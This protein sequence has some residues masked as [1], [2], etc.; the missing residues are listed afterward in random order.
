ML[1]GLHLFALVLSLT[2]LFC[3]ILQI[4]RLRVLSLYFNRDTILQFFSWIIYGQN[5][6]AQPLKI[7]DIY[8]SIGL[9]S[10]NKIQKDRLDILKLLGKKIM[11]T[12]N[13]H[14][15]SEITLEWIFSMTSWVAYQEGERFLNSYFFPSTTIVLVSFYVVIF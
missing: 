5:L 13:Y 12:G 3:Y 14:F 15:I 2:I 9:I 1:S 8:F 6:G 11:Q 7:M 10:V 4:M